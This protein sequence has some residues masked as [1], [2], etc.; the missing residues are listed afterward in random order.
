[1]GNGSGQASVSEDHGLKI[2][3]SGDLRIYSVGISTGG[4]AEIRM[5]SGDLG[6]HVTATTL[7]VVG[8]EFVRDQVSER[9]FSN[10]IDIKIE[11][12]SKG[13]PYGDGYF[14]FVYARLVLHYLSKM[15]LQDALRELCRVLKGDGKIFVVVRSVACAEAQD[16]NSIFDAENGLTTYFFDGVSYSRYFHSEESIQRYLM[17]A[18]FSIEHVETYHEQLCHDFQR[19]NPSEKVQHLIEVLARKISLKVSFAADREGCRVRLG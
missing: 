2:L 10:Q 9:G 19:K 4:E 3:T 13:L 18:G 17:S 6:R 11:D 15:A 5:V 8:A 1:M 16:E 12:V 14:D 7:D